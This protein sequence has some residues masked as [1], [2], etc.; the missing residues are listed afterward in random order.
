MFRVNQ[1]VVSEIELFE[2]G[3]SP[4][5]LWLQ[6]E[7]VVRLTLHDVADADQF[8]I[9]SQGFQLRPNVRRPQV[10]P[11]DHAEN[12]RR[13]LRQLKKPTCLFQCL[14]HLNGNRALKFAAVQL[15][16]QIGW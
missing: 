14:A 13:A 5:K 8:G 11:A 15:R 16:L 6:Q 1:N 10:S 3:N 7:P 9:S 2:R 12:R 4:Q